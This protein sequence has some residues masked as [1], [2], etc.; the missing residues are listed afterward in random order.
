[1]P[2]EINFHLKDTKFE[3]V[4]YGQCAVLEMEFI[5]PQEV[6]DK[7]N[8]SSNISYVIII[9]SYHEF[10]NLRLS[11]INFVKNA[12]KNEIIDL[13]KEV[14]V[15]I[16][17]DTFANKLFCSYKS[18]KE[19]RE[20]KVFPSKD[21]D[22][23]I[24]KVLYSE[25]AVLDS[26]GEIWGENSRRCQFS[27][28]NDNCLFLNYSLDVSDLQLTNESSKFTEIKEKILSSKENGEIGIISKERQL[29]RLKELKKEAEKNEIVGFFFEKI[30]IR[31]ACCHHVRHRR[32]HVLA[33]NR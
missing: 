16:K 22:E 4:N 12:K 32:K 2:A 24:R 5:E 3:I 28:E 25:P 1:M 8:D 15:K 7:N 30:E 20:S 13:G 26:G 31:W 19:I 23:G 21:N 14:R 27:I 10:T 9:A 17:N 29:S 6:K 18:Y 33:P 11:S